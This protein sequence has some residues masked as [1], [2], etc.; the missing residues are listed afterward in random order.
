MPGRAMGT[1]R[2]TTLRRVAIAL[3]LALVGLLLLSGVA[4]ADLLTPE[5]GG[6]RN[7]DSIDTLYKLVFGLGVIIFIGVEGTL[8]YCLVRYRAR[9]GAVASQIHGNT[10]LEIGWTVGAAV[11]LVFIAVFTFA[12]LPSIRNPPNSD[13]GLSNTAGITGGTAVAQSE[14]LPPNGK[15]LRINVNGQ[16]YVWRYDYTDGDGNPL[17]DVFSYEEMVVPAGV[18]VTLAIRAQDVAHSWWIPKLGGKFDAVP[19][20]TNFTWFKVPSDQ[21]GSVFR[22]QC[23]ELC[24]RNHANMIATVRVLTPSDFEAWLEA[25]RQQ[26]EASNDAAAEQRKR[27]DAGENP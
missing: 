23:A 6:S 20:H 5:S 14:R 7:A 1:P 22:G 2:P 19:K 3:P 9:K 16:Q 13:E 21:A 17:N 15:S 12:T 10:Q 26:I 4:S 8:I 24:G 18:T 25:K 11:I 27:V